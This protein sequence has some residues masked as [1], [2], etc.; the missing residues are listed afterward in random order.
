MLERVDLT[1]ST[2]RQTPSPGCAAPVPFCPDPE[3][4]AVPLDARPELAPQRRFDTSSGLP[5]RRPP[6]IVESELWPCGAARP[7]LTFDDQATAT[8][9][10]S[11]L[12]ST[13][14]DGHDSACH[15]ARPPTNNIRYP[16]M[17]IFK[18]GA[19]SVSG[20]ATVIPQM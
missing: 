9:H 13:F 8:T 14:R 11:Q 7:Q 6:V 18:S 15:S 2:R 20:L 1:A 16:W 17:K 4:P 5:F 19:V 3:R 12:L 10:R